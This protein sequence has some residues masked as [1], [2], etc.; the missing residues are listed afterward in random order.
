MA[1]ILLIEDD[2]LMVNLY[3]KIFARAGYEV[4][5]AQRGG[6]GLE[7]AKDTLPNLILLDIMM[8]EMD[9]FEVLAILK[10]DD[11]TKSIPVIALTNLAGEEDAKRALALGVAK[12]VIKSEHDPREVLQ[13]VK[14]VLSPPDAK[15]V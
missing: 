14:D 13:M 9:G 12:Y 8:P 2:P 4:E 15:V 1:K 11:K 6:E 5:I 10:K 3:R 7:K